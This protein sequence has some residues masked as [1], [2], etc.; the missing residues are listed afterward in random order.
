MTLQDGHLVILGVDCEGPGLAPAESVS[1]LAAEEKERARRFLRPEHARRFMAGRY[2]LRRVLARV[3]GQSPQMI[4]LRYTEHGKPYLPDG[5]A[6]NL[7]NSG[8]YAYIAVAAAGRLGVDIEQRIPGRDLPGIASRYFSSREQEA[9]AAMDATQRLRTFYRIWTRKEALLKAAGSG[10]STPLGSFSVEACEHCAE[11]CLLEGS[12]DLCPDQWDLR[13]V[14]APP[15]YE[16]AVAWNCEVK[17]L[18]IFN[19][20]DEFLAKAGMG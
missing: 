15:A 5:P 18:A 14:A 16:A 11:S 7:S 3:T 1:P 12:G 20:V 4:E 2:A 19:S 9:L 10:L 17:S 8:R 6:F 13:S